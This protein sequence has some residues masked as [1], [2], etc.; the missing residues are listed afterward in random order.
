MRVLPWSDSACDGA[1]RK[2]I[3]SSRTEADDNVNDVVDGSVDDDDDEDVIARG[4]EKIFI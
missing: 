1:T 4:G 3:K 2:L